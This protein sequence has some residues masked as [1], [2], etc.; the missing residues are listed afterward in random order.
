MGFLLWI[1]AVT[2]VPLVPQQA[3][4]DPLLP[5]TVTAPA[6]PCDRAGLTD[7]RRLDCWLLESEA[8]EARCAAKVAELQSDLDA[9]IVH[10]AGV[11]ALP[12]EPSPSPWPDR[13]IGFAAGAL[14]AL[15]A[16][17]AAR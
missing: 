15:I 14:V 4:A 17:I 6:G 9:R 7:L 8:R 2:L 16:V 12:V 11:A 5:G 13:A 1:Q 3:S 10:D